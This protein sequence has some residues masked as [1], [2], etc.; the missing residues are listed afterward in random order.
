MT[1]GFDLMDVSYEMNLPESWEAYLQRLNGKQR[2]EVRRKFRRLHEA[3]AIEF[4]VVSNL[5]QHPGA[6]DIFLKLFRQNRSGKVRF[7]TPDMICYFKSL[8]AAMADDRMLRLFFLRLDRV[9]ASSV[10]CF[11]DGE[12]L[13]LYN[14]GYDNRFS[15]LSVGLLCKLM[16]IKYAIENGKK[17]YDFLKGAE[18]YKQRLGGKPVSLY[19]WR[20]DLL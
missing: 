16:S 9:Y 14:N 1:V 18:S 3:G 6:M 7:M 5:N 15:S 10:L 19:R 2:H 12:T 4:Q 13:Y 17:R 8:A 11:D 20:I